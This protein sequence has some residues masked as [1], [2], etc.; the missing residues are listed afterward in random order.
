MSNPMDMMRDFHLQNNKKVI[1]VNL[2]VEEKSKP[3]RLVIQINL[4]DSFT[5]TQEVPTSNAA[6][7][8]IKLEKNDQN[9]ALVDKLETALIA[10]LQEQQIK[11]KRN[12]KFHEFSFDITTKAQA[13]A[14]HDFCL[15]NPAISAKY[16]AQN[17]SL[18]NMFEQMRHSEGEAEGAT[19]AA[20]RIV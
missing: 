9:D 13:Q 8:S 10:K 18:V 7:C 12:E 1:Q 4:R 11:A 5:W 20:K 14:L 6:Q 3:T 15:T 16:K 19:S 2:Y 17:I